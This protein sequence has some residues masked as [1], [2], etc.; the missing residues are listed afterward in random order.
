M[1]YND[2][3]TAASIMASSLNCQRRFGGLNGSTGFDAGFHSFYLNYD[4]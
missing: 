3:L 2:A 1:T 4:L